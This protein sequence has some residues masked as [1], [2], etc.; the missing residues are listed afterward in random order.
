MPTQFRLLGDVG[1]SVGGRDIDLGFQRQQ[2]VLA[3]LL[4]DA[5]R[6]VSVDELVERVWGERAPQRARTALYSYL[7]RL[8]GALAVAEDVDLVRR[9]GGYQLGVDEQHV[10]LHRFRDLVVRARACPDDRTAGPLLADA[11]ALWRGEAF[12]G[13]D[14]PWLDSVRDT[15][16]HDRFAAELDHADIALRSGRHADLLA[17]LTG[18]TADRPLDERLAG[19]LMVALCRS[20]RQ[21]DAIGHYHHIRARLAEDIGADPC[22]PLQRLYH[23]IL[24]GDQDFDDPVEPARPPA[25]R[26]LP[27]APAWFVGRGREL[28][29]LAAAVDRSAGVMAVAAITGAGG[30]GKSSLALHW[31]HQHVEDFP[32]G[33]LFLDLR[34]CTPGEEPLSPAAAIRVLLAGLGV[35]PDRVPLD[36]DARIGLY[37]S[38]VADRRMLVVLD[39]AADAAQVAPLLPGSPAC[40]VLVTSRDRLAG[41]VNTYGAQPLSVTGLPAVEARALLTARLGVARLS[42][43]P[44]AV[45]DVI[46]HC[47]GLPLALTIV[48]GR[49]AAQPSL[50]IED[51]A[52]EL[53]DPATRLSALD[54][55]PD[56]SLPAAL[57]RSHATLDPDQA[58]AFALLGLAPGPDISVPAAAALLDLTPALAGAL[59]RSLDRV[60]LVQQPNP[61]CYRLDELT[62]LFAADRAHRDI[63]AADRDSALRRLA[64]FHRHPAL[65]WLP[66]YHRPLPDLMSPGTRPRRIFAMHGPDSGAER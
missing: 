21:A 7:S 29:A 19:Q 56:A 28:T 44:R 57:G 53:R 48:A 52:A 43:E 32:D 2:C 60:S 58:A 63:P 41:L 3:V 24:T 22:P 66:R 9:N 17:E 59:L 8:R 33:Q 34:G 62:R 45:D 25:P 42:A 46:T 12:S 54:D 18:R 51:L 20:G 16:E 6:V 64:D 61:G 38:K 49:A 1:A 37:R 11:L 13:L 36:L 15:A 27:P 10:D 4:V 40:T 31:A 50:P 30:V 55:G 35:G 14:S 39:N 26:Q 5:N 47:A 65:A 23:Q